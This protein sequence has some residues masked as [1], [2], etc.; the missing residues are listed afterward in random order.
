MLE[1]IAILTGGQVISEELGLKLENTDLE[2]LGKAKTIKVEKENTTIINGEGKASISRTESH[3]SRPR[4][5]IQLQ[6]MTGKNFR[7]GLRNLQEVLQ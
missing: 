7:K 4:L 6:T 5:K 2:M 1:D 3:R